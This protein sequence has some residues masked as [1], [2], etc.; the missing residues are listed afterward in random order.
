MYKVLSL[1]LEGYNRHKKPK[2]INVL[3][4]IYHR[5]VNERALGRRKKV[6]FILFYCCTHT[7]VSHPSQGIKS[8]GL[9]ICTGQAKR[10][11]SS[12]KEEMVPDWTGTWE[13][14]ESST[15]DP[16]TPAGVVKTT[17]P[18]VQLSL[19]FP[20][21]RGGWGKKNRRANEK[22]LRQKTAER[23]RKMTLLQKD[24]REREVENELLWNGDKRRNDSKINLQ[25]LEC[26]D[27][28]WETPTNSRWKGNRDNSQ[29]RNKKWVSLSTKIYSQERILI[30][31]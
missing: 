6:I 10:W 29:K 12:Q 5:N 1:S 22:K 13:K 8:C 30:H 4:K 27:V 24:A 28:F 17:I 20:L 21:N 25:G 16:R 18:S 15:A 3:N 2:A 14:G 23:K 7:Q 11:S 9:T 26:I 31:F 19:V